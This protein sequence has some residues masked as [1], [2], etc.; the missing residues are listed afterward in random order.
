MP[1]MLSPMFITY[2]T[3][4][5]NCAIAFVDINWKRNMLSNVYLIQGLVLV[6]RVT[7]YS[8]KIY[9]YLKCGRLCMGQNSLDL[10]KLILDMIFVQYGIE[11]E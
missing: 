2:V 8:L 3:V 10:T 1:Y 6:W 11:I 5:L 7:W 9:W 4:L